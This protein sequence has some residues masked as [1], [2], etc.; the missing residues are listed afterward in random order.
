[1]NKNKKIVLGLLIISAII[2]FLMS[3]TNIFDI[4]NIQYNRKVALI[5]DS[6]DDTDRE[7]LE[8]GIL[9][10]AE[11]R[12][13]DLSVE[14]LSKP[15]DTEEQKCIISEK[16]KEG[17]GALVILP[18]DPGEIRSW[19]EGQKIT[20]PIVYLYGMPV[21]KRKSIAA[22]YNAEN[23]GK[24]LL[25]KIAEGDE[26]NI[27]LIAGRPINEETQIIVN[28]LGTGLSGR[29]IDIIEY[30]S[31]SEIP[32][33][34]ESFAK[35]GTEAVLIGDSPRSVDAI[36][37]YARHYRDWERRIYSLGYNSVTLHS[38]EDGR[39]NGAIGWSDY[40]V[41]AGAIQS[42]SNLLRGFSYNYLVTVDEYY[43]DAQNLYE[44]KKV[45][46]RK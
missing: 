36:Q 1:M 32:G 43:I 29:Q 30:S 27:L 40:E 16:I 45:F 42:L 10:E 34:L 33:K 12:D 13:I 24:E 9:E 31:L 18:T 15:L 6:V 39:I 19:L 46:P 38:I 4:K 7:E 3:V 44:N 41:G 23:A 5:M 25:E 2:T 35:G 20:I 21:N 22:G 11:I 28:V 26:N 8:K 17:A 37:N 14:Y